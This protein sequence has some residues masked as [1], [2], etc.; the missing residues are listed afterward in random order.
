MMDT[1]RVDMDTGTDTMAE[2]ITEEDTPV[3][4]FLAPQHSFPRFIG[5]S[6]LFNLSKLVLHSITDTHLV[7]ICRKVKNVGK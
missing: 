3:N 7:A 1:T 4:N 6:Q 2:I 5:N